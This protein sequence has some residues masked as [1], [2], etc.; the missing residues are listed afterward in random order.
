[1]VKSLLTCPPSAVPERC[2][3]SFGPR[4]R[5]DDARS[6]YAE[7]SG[8]ALPPALVSS[9]S[10]TGP[11]L[12]LLSHQFTDNDTHTHAGG[13]AQR[14]PTARTA[15]P[16]PMYGGPEALE[17]IILQMRTHISAPLERSWTAA[18]CV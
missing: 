16:R 7:S 13:G 5:G 15:A 14:H 12:L 3:G 2:C 10:L 18:G 11:L 4:R 9:A 8:A 1:M 6:F 17:R